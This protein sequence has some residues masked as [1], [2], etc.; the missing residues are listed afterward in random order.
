MLTKRID[1]LIA[2][3]QEK[4]WKERNEKDACDLWLEASAQLH[5]Q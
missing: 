3:G 4:L 5:F 1:E 2:S